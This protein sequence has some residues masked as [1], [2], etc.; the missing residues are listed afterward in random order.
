MSDL[1]CDT[2]TYRNLVASSDGA[3]ELECRRY[4]PQLSRVADLTDGGHGHDATVVIAWPPVAATDWCGEYRRE[5][6]DDPL[7]QQAD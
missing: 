2:C 1:T 6:N 7:S 5:N 3:L 4:P